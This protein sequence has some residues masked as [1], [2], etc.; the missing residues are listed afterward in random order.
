MRILDQSNFPIH[1]KSVVCLSVH[2][3]ICPDQDKFPLHALSCLLLR[4][5]A[6]VRILFRASSACKGPRDA[7][8]PSF[9][10]ILIEIQ[11][12]KRENAFI[13]FSHYST[14]PFSTEIRNKD[15]KEIFAI[16]IKVVKNSK[17]FNDC[18]E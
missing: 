12:P 8:L 10:E 6:H 5:T 1:F 17:P 2:L 7:L 16:S 3:L 4:L 18:D 14:N 11:T 15:R 13:T 9:M